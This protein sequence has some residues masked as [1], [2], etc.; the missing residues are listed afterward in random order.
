[1]LNEFYSPQ[2]IFMRKLAI[3]CTLAL[4]ILLSA[5]ASKAQGK[6]ELFGGYSFVRPPVTFTQSAG[7]PILVNTHRNLNGWE[8]TGAYKVLGPLSLAADF[9]GASGSFHGAKVH[10]HTYMFGPQLR[11][12]GLISPFAHLLVGAAHESFDAAPVTGGSITGPSQT[13]F[14]TAVGVGL[15]LKVFPFISIRPIQVDYLATHFNSRTQ[16]Q[17]R[18][19][20][21]LVLRF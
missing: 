16:N 1:M 21:G 7:L 15:D 6:I 17:P 5:N 14:A 19:S 8:A 11:F 13:S 4:L 2:V 20:A 10:L 3:G 18:I 12:P 9:A